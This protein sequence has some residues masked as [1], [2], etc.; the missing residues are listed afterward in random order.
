MKQVELYLLQLGILDPISPLFVL[1]QL[2]RYKL[3]YLKATS[4]F[5]IQLFFIED[6]LFLASLILE[7]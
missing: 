1:H 5:L 6:D 2:L 7:T 3:T 4:L